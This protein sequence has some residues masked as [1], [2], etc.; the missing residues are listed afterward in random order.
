M[1][2][3]VSSPFS[4]V[5]PSFCP[6]RTSLRAPSTFSRDLHSAPLDPAR[7]PD[8][9]H[10]KQPVDCL[11]PV[12]LR[13]LGLVAILACLEVPLPENVF[14]SLYFVLYFVACFHFFDNRWRIE[15]FLWQSLTFILVI[16]F[17]CAYKILFIQESKLLRLKIIAEKNEILNSPLREQKLNSV[18]VSTRTKSFIIFLNCSLFS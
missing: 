2:L 5:V 11:K 13:L 1:Y 6:E 17:L 16:R 3:R 8:D 14:H 4:F 10:A 7:R 15:I 12:A 18:Q 9:R